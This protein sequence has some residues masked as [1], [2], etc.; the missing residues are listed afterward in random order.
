MRPRRARLGLDRRRY[1]AD[2]KTIDADYDKLKVWIGL[3]TEPR[4]T[5]RSSPWKPGEKSWTVMPTLPKRRSADAAREEMGRTEAGIETA[6]PRRWHFACV[7]A[8]E[9]LK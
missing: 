7:E 4:T 2:V 8:V 9:E 5:S 3:N 1:G 6:S